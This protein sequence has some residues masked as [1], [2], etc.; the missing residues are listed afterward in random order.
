[1]SYNLELKQNSGSSLKVNIMTCD[2]MN[3]CDLQRIK[4]FV[5]KNIRKQ[6][7]QILAGKTKIMILGQLGF[8]LRRRGKSF[9][10]CVLWKKFLKI[11]F[12]SK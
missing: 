5:E 1:M 12:L 2:N 9:P 7:I 6:D 10:R 11:A 8:G 3:E 4:E